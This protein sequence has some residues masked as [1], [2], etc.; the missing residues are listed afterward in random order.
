MNIKEFADSLE[1]TLP[2]DT[3]QTELKALWW[4]AKGDWSRAHECV[5]SLSSPRAARIHAYLHR[6]EGDLWN[7]DY[8]Y[9][10]AGA[11]RPSHSLEEEFRWI[12]KELQGF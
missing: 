1:S 4:D 3:W 2:P 5:D 11:N 7:A 10:R 8:W 9:S 12:L 6:K